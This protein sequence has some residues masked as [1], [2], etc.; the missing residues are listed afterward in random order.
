[1]ATKGSVMDGKAGGLTTAERAYLIWENEGRPHG[2]D[3]QH[4]AQAEAEAAGATRA[5]KL[6]PRVAAAMTAS[7][8][9]SR[10]TR[11]AS[12]TGTKKPPTGT[13]AKR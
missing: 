6:P 2:R 5:R 12:K 3:A 4:W 9:T 10:S 11:A 13:R 7:S 1:M 8:G